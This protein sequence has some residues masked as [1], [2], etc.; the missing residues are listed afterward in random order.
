M[1]LN[2]PLVEHGFCD[3]YEA[4]DVR[5]DDEITLLSVLLGGFPGILENRG[6]DVAQT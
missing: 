5:T 4:G 3:F 6:H 1:Q 2:N